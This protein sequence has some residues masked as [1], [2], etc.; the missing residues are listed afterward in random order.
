MYKVAV[1]LPLVLLCAACVAH[2]DAP[3]GADTT[4]RPVAPSSVNE[5]ARVDSP[6]APVKSL[7]DPERHMHVADV[8]AGMKGYGLSVFSGTA[9]EKFDVEVVDVVRN[10]NPQYDVVLIRCHGANLEHTGAVAGMS[11]SPIYLYDSAGKGKMIGAFAYGWQLSKDPLAGVQPIE[12]MLALPTTAAPQLADAGNSPALDAVATTAHWSLDDVPLKPWGRH[13]RAQPLANAEA[14]INLHM[15]PLATP[16]M[17]AGLS[18]NTLAQ[19]LPLFR[20]SGLVPMQA[21][22][23]G[24]ST[25]AASLDPKIEPGSVLAVPLLSGDIELTAVGT[26]TETVG[27]QIFGFGHPFQ[28]E[29]R[30]DLP[31]GGGSIATVVANYM[32]SFKLGFLS[33]ASGTLTTDQTV[34][35]AGR[36]GQVAPMAPIDVHV[37]YDDHSIDKMYHFKAAIHPKL[38]PLI[39]AAAVSGAITGEHDLP[40]FHT[41][42]YDLKMDF[43]NGQSVQ[44]NNTSVNSGPGDIVADIAL[45]MMATAQNPFQTVPVSRI[46]ATVHVSRQAR[47]AQIL[48]VMVPRSKYEPGETIKAYISYQPFHATVAT[49][50]VEFELS[51]DLPNGT[52]QLTVSDWQHYLDDERTANGFKFTAS[53]IDELFSVLKDVTGIKHNAVYI[54]LSRQPDGV[55]VGRTAM[56]RL[57]SSFRQVWADAGRSDITPFVSS[58]VKTIPTD[59][60]MDGSADFTITI[61]K[62]VKVEVSSQVKPGAAPVPAAPTNAP[63]GNGAASPTGNG[64]GKSGGD[65]PKG[66]PSAGEH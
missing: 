34:G 25:Q 42:I 14:G 1:A 12:Y 18:A 53:N 48:S 7:F 10:F 29:G 38:T 44:V 59:W 45:P 52:Y 51:H 58:T 54:R 55:A 47:E 56:P 37:I 8:K 64:A 40:E 23:G 57:P 30:I 39:A 5:L 24:S 62:H 9:I 28:G 13:L 43:S 60:V 6:V 33:H 27:D 17:T 49:L 26:C 22:T 65:A 31:F 16:L 15:Q 19:L 36:M 61:Q 63:A 66:S 21:G 32:T 4:T 11:G 3:G 50:P 41:V 20:E 35:V 2:A 46:T